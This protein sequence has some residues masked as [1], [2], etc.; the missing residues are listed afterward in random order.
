MNPISD[1][2]EWAGNTPNRK[3]LRTWTVRTP[4]EMDRTIHFSIRQLARR[5]EST[6]CN[7][8]FQ[9]LD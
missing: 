2:Y 8:L 9:T 6:V 7:Q 4:V 3:N 5:M 1:A